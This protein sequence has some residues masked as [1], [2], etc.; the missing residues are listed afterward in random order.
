MQILKA[1]ITG[2]GKWQQK[3][4]EFQ[5]VNQLFF[6]LNEE[7]KSTI[8]QFITAILFG[9]PVK[10]KKNHD[11]TPKEGGVY[12]GKLWIEVPAYGELMVERFKNKNHG[13]ASVLYGETVCDENF[14]QTVLEPLTEETFHKVFTLN[15][16]QLTQLN[17]LQEKDLH[18]ALISLGASG[19]TDLFQRRQEYVLEAQKIYKRRG[20]KQ[21]LNVKIQEWKAINEEIR[22]KISEEAA[23]GKLSSQ[24]ELLQQEIQKSKE[25]LAESDKRL[26]DYQQQKVNWPQYEEWLSLKEQLEL[27]FADTDIQQMKALYQQYLETSQRIDEL[28]KHREEES[29]KLAHSNEYYFYLEN[30]T[31]IKSLEELETPIIQTQE[32]L[33]QQQ[34]D[35]GESERFA[36][37]GSR[38]GWSMNHPPLPL[39]EEELK[40]FAEKNKTLHTDK[41]QLEVKLE[42]AQEQ[43]DSIEADLSA[44]ETKNPSFSRRKQRRKS[45]SYLVWYVLALVFL[46]IGVLRS[47][48]MIPFFLLCLLC[49][50]VGISMVINNSAALSKKKRKWQQKLAHLDEQQ[51]KVEVIRKNVDELN[52]ELASLEEAFNQTRESNHLGEIITLDTLKESTSDLENYLFYLK[53]IQEKQE[54]EAQATAE[55]QHYKEQTRFLYPWLPLQDKEFSEQFRMIKQFIRKMEETSY[56]QENQQILLIQQEINRTEEK[57]TDVLE[58]LKPFMEQYQIVYPAEVAFIID[59]G[60]K[61]KRLSIR[62]QALAPLIDQLYPVPITAEQLSQQIYEEEENHRQLQTG[63]EAKITEEQR[64]QVNV[65]SMQKS[66]NLDMLYREE[67]EKKAEIEELALDWGKF[68]LADN[69]MSDLSTE[70]SQQQLPQLLA[71]ASHYLGILTHGGYRELIFSENTLYVVNDSQRFSIYELSAGTQDQVVMA[72]RF[73]FMSLEQNRQLCPVIIDDGWLHY[74]YKRKRQLAELLADFGKE[75]QIICFSSDREMVSYYRELNQPIYSLSN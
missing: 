14:L 52:E 32:K 60:E 41:S 68:R 26:A 27:K 62:K 46:L 4:F 38:W 53:K 12:G 64:V 31:Q 45:S 19:S 65:D 20:V 30:E 59:E 69:V 67:A 57:Q 70:L 15:Q 8:Y 63:F 9:F 5:K 7:G 47:S 44:Y 2:F 18:E 42:L 22:Q 36:E 11:Y 24:Q 10:N 37:L 48:L 43:R 13:K 6:G 16:E 3:T 71:K 21:P 56:Q 40:H 66:G 75:H 39:T 61:Q 73:A 72:I 58:Q 51:E 29:R 28:K 33:R 54:L 25:E 34:L 35:S 1:E 50:G 74:D 17:Q 23:F 49:V 55:L